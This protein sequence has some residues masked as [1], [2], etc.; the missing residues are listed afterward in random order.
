[1]SENTLANIRDK[2]NQAVGA[3]NQIKNDLLSLNED[4][5]YN[6]KMYH[7]AEKAQVFLQKVALETQEQIKFHLSDLVSTALKSIFGNNAYKFEIDFQAKGQ[8]SARTECNFY[9]AKDESKFDPM[10]STGGGPVDVASFGLRVAIWAI[11]QPRTRNI[12]I[13]DEPFKFLSEDLIPLAG[14][15]ISEISHKL[16]V[17][18]I[19][20]THKNELTKSANSIFKVIK[21]R[22]ISQVDCNA[23]LAA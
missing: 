16:G 20:V 22:N 18:F 11:S 2:I 13:L 10:A 14:E 9:F 6:Q 7:A 17:Q 5:K 19:F 4:Y 8:K 1:L 23:C 12:I 21:K 3:R 15:I